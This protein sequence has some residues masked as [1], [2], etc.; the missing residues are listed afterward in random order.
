M[1]KNSTILRELVI[2]LRYWQSRYRLEYAGL[3]R[4][5]IKIKQISAEM[6]RLQKEGKP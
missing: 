5:K 6:R 3:L 4:L 2:E 1:K